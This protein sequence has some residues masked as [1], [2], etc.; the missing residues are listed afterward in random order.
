M[1]ECADCGRVEVA[2]GEIDLTVAADAGA[3]LEAVELDAARLEDLAGGDARRARA[4]DAHLGHEWA[5]LARLA[6][7]PISRT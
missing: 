2:L 6:G 4:D 3:L 1:D 5:S 7:R